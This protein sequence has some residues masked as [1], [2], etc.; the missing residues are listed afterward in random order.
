MDGSQLTNE[1]L[2]LMHDCKPE[3]SK[4]LRPPTKSESSW[5]HVSRGAFEAVLLCTIVILAFILFFA[6]GGKH[7]VNL[8]TVVPKC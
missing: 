5:C 1:E 4:S 6:G 2:E 7:E 3:D 8:P